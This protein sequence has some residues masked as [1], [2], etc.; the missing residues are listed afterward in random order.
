MN[1]FVRSAL[2]IVLLTYLSNYLQL[3]TP[4]L[5]LLIVIFNFIIYFISLKSS[6]ITLE[7][8]SKGQ[9]SSETITH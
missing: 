1:V 3:L 6:R 7:E 4:I 8:I 9:E 2:F 5:Q